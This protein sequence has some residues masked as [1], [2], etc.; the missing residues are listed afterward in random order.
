MG[1]LLA[2]AAKCSITP[3]EE[4][5]KQLSKAEGTKFDGIHEPMMFRCIVVSDGIEKAVIGGYDLGRAPFCDKLTEVLNEKYGIKPENCVFSATHNHEAFAPTLREGNDFD[6]MKL[7]PPM[8][9]MVAKPVSEEM[10][11]CSEWIFDQVVETIGEAIKNM[12]PAKVGF[13]KGTSYINACRDLPTP[14]GPIQG[15]NFH[16]PSDHELLVIRFDDL[17]GNTIGMFLNHAT[18]SNALVWNLYDGTYPKINVDVGGGVSRFVENANQNKFPVI[19]AQGAAGDQNPIVRSVWRIVEVDENGKYSMSQH[20]FH[21]EDNLLQ[22]A[23][24]TS[25]QGMEVLELS[26]K[27]DNFTD[28]CSIAGCETYREIPGRKSYVQL[29][30]YSDLPYQD[31][32]ENISNKIQC[33]D[34]PEPVPLGANIPMRFRLFRLNNDISF[35]SVNCEA[36]SNL[37]KLTKSIIPTE[38]T[39]ICTV[40]FGGVGYIMDA[41][42]QWYNGFGTSNSLAWNGEMVNEAFTDGYTELK[43][44][45]F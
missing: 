20:V 13:K 26:E 8:P 45:L 9:Q 39:A 21:Y 31:S 5:V 35:A 37:G 1:K 32:Y 22:L 11:K 6:I 24:L 29:G 33:G 36:Y 17:E 3:S 40:T 30:L 12:K 4:I 16:G 23:G 7:Y 10:Y 14:I 18:H 25:T 41:E 27:I 19:W 15:N 38:A 34:R 2:G 43:N 44:K 28:E 42:G